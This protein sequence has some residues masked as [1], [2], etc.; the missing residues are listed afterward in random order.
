[1]RGENHESVMRPASCKAL[2][3]SLKR[4]SG[5]IPDGE[6]EASSA[7]AY[8]TSRVRYK[9]C[10][11]SWAV[12]DASTRPGAMTWSKILRTMSRGEGSRGEVMG[13]ELVEA[14]GVER[15]WDEQGAGQLI[16]C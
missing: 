8:E 2:M 3:V 1:M 6:K 13:S 4:A 12:G 10:F 11:T 5:V 14:L 9:C 16:R 15:A 7:V